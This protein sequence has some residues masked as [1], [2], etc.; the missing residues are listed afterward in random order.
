MILT[1]TND[2]YKI[3]PLLQE[4]ETG[5]QLSA[6]GKL[7]AKR[8]GGRRPAMS[9]TRDSSDVASVGKDSS[10]HSSATTIRHLQDFDEFSATTVSRLSKYEIS[11]S[12]V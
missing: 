1:E 10:H 8:E 6:G 5:G 11:H 12:K 7:S 9:S 3:G 4:V 2:R